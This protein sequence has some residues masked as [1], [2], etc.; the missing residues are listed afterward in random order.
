MIPPTRAGKRDAKS[1]RDPGNNQGGDMD[2]RAGTRVVAGVAA[3]SFGLF[4]KM[5]AWM[6]M[7]WA[8]P[9]T[10]LIAAFKGN[11]VLAVVGAVYGALGLLG[12]WICNGVIRR[13]RVRLVLAALGTLVLGGAVLLGLLYAPQAGQS[14]V[15]GLGMAL[16]MVIAG[17]LLVVE[18][19]MKREVS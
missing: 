18:A 2:L 5:A 17:V 8:L 3:D 13:G 11:L 12:W 14:S 7:V 4:G 10:V 15:A 9:L 6:L 16:L 1:A 19:F